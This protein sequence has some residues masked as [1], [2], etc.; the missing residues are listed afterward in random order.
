MKPRPTLKE[1]IRTSE[2]ESF[3]REGKTPPPASPDPDH[4]RVTLDLPKELHDALQVVLETRSLTL[5]QALRE[6]LVEYI[7]KDWD[8]KEDSPSSPG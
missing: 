4:I 5:D 8:W 1:V 6:M 7:M 3:I 2:V